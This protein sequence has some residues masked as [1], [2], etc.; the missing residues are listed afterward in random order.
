MEY[1]NYVKS[2]AHIGTSKNSETPVLTEEDEQFL[3]RVTSHDEQPPPLPT[4]PRVQDL[5]V[6]GEAQG[7]DAQLALF[8][9]AQNIALPE[10]P[11]EPKTVPEFTRDLGVESEKMP[12]NKPAKNTWSWL[13]RDSRDHKR[14]VCIDSCVMYPMLTSA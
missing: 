11:D 12:D 9:G 3:N 8:E 4:R 7:N 2:K 13:R 5:P 10:T 14:K 6:A 1:L